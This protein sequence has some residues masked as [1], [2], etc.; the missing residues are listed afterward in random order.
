MKNLLTAFLLLA[1]TAGADPTFTLRTESQDPMKQCTIPASQ[2]AD[3]SLKVYSY[4]D[5]EK[6]TL[7][8]AD[9][10]VFGYGTNWDFS[11]SMVLVNGT[12]NTNDSYFAVN[13]T[14]SDV[15][16]SGSYFYQ[17]MQTNAVSGKAFVLGRGIMT[18]AR[19]PITGGPGTLNLQTIVN[20]DQVYNLNSGPWVL[21]N[22]AAWLQ[23]Q[24]LA[25]N[26]WQNPASATNWT[27][28][29]DGKEIT[30]T[31][32]NFTS[33]DVVIPDMLD[34]LPVTGFGTIFSP[35]YVG[36]VITSIS[37]GNNITTVGESAFYGCTALTSVSLPNATT[38]GE[39]AF[40]G[41]TA[42]TSVSLPNA[43]TV[44]DW[45]F[46]SCTA[47]T[48]VSLP[49]ATTVGD[50]G[51]GS[52]TALTSV[53]LPNATTVRESAFGS[54]TA[55]T[56]VSLPNA[57]TIGGWAFQGCTALTSVTFA[58]NAPAEATDV[59]TGSP[60]VTNYVANPTATG[61]GAT[62]N[63]MPVVRMNG[64]FDEVTIAGTNLQTTLAG[65]VG[66]DRTIT[67][68]G[69]TGSLETNL[70]FTVEG[71]ETDMSNYA[72]VATPISTLSTGAVITVTPT[73]QQKVYNVTASASTTTLTNDFSALGLNGTTNISY[74]VG[75]T[76]PT[77]NTL[78]TIWDSRIEWVGLA[79]ATPDLTVTGRYEFAFS[80]SDGVKIQ[81]RQ[82]YPTVYPWVNIGLPDTGNTANPTLGGKAYLTIM[83]AGDS[84]C[85]FVVIYPNSELSMIQSSIY[86]GA[87]VDKTNAVWSTR[88]VGVSNAQEVGT[89]TT[90]NIINSISAQTY[91]STHA[92]FTP[93]DGIYYQYTPCIKFSWIRNAA[94]TAGIVATKTRIKKANQNE[95]RHANA[96]GG[97]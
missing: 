38:I 10:A 68:N 49:N 41:C 46:G 78:S 73:Y 87:N 25:S 77:T 22:S 63:G 4:T 40:V 1:L 31:S 57:T 95:V 3:L 6:N 42:L 82:T 50:W 64:F 88:T 76:Y 17:V 15:P 58:Q 66:T 74:N 59:Y 30:L 27:W 34:G 33:L 43:T 67:I 24:S 44:G 96:G 54:C 12:A 79:S 80:T 29:S 53:S 89:P 48:S 91:T 69:V 61:W 26:A 52:C 2:L 18:V 94:A 21:T 86:F 11:A 14:P 19:S 72:L 8:S 32:Y 9:S 36:S 60:N 85:Y 55:L 7:T 71:G 5:G 37:G 16:A 39:S 70:Q 13:L 20:W 65:K 23:V 90:N 47:L 56:S 28:T 93:T 62:W 45:V 97:F 51:F 35:A 92:V 75:I 84:N 81:G 83:S